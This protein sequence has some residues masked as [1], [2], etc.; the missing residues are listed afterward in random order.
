[1]A[2]KA[3]RRRPL[4]DERLQ[5]L[6]ALIK[7]SDSVE[8]K[9]TV[10]ESNQRS[11]VEALEMDPLDAQIRQVWFFDTPDLRLERGGVVVRARRAQGR[12]D[13]S[14][15]KLRPVHPDTLPTSLRA[16]ADVV[17]EVDAMPDGF[18]CSAS[19]RATG[20]D[21][22]AVREAVAGRR[23]LRKLFSRRQRGFFAEHAPEGVTLDDLVPL[24][25]IFVLKLKAQPP[26]AKRKVA[27]ELW[28]YP[29]G[30]RVLE[31][32]TKCL[33]SEALEVA[34]QGREY[35]IRR[36]IDITG[37]QTTKTHTA[38]RLLSKDLAA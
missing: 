30:T 19:Y 20:M 12:G 31:L 11:A 7:G 36:G 16:N 35:L 4:L 23:P 14:V 10:R 24:G 5:E 25:P 38:L 33:P 34:T 22:L 27:A 2:T 3:I 21:P 17:V 6:I 1:M 13:D 26:G 15:V 8:L 28:A 37:P 9:L 32:S 18:V 29:G